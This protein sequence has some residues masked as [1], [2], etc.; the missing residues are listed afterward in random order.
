MSASESPVFKSKSKRR[1]VIIDSDEEE[2]MGGGDV[3]SENGDGVRGGEDGGEVGSE[4]DGDERMDTNTRD[5]DGKRTEASE[6]V[7]RAC[8][9]KKKARF[10]N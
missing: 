7:I 6:E 8:E 2:E 10:K 5:S 4:G 3:R 9:I 1:R